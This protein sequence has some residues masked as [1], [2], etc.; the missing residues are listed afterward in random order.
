MDQATKK[1]LI[2]GTVD[3]GLYKFN[4]VKQSAHHNKAHHCTQPMFSLSSSFVNKTE[5]T[6]QIL[7]TDYTYDVGSKDLVI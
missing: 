5:Y 6:N 2:E 3:G 4:L 1:V 7:L